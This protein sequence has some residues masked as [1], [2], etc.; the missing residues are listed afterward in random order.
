M[1]RHIGLSERERFLLHSSALTTLSEAG[2]LKMDLDKAIM[3]VL[4]NR[5]RVMYKDI[6]K[7]ERI[8]EDIQ[9][10]LMASNAFYEEFFD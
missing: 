7:L 2:V 10:E 3:L 6:S 8:N 5:C 9:D 1:S 4:K